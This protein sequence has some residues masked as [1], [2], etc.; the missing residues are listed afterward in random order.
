MRGSLFL[1]CFHS[2]LQ[3][4]L[5]R[6]LI[7]A[8][9]LQPL[10]RSIQTADLLLP[11]NRLDIPRLQFLIQALYLVHMLVVLTLLLLFGDVVAD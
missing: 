2:F 3:C 5:F 1:S 11:A 4:V 7:L 6:P 8:L 10:N 9:S